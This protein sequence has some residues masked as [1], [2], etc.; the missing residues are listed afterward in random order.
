MSLQKFSEMHIKLLNILIDLWNE[1]NFQSVLK[2]YK[3]KKYLK[4]SFNEI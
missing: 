1:W 3:L 2:I 4:I